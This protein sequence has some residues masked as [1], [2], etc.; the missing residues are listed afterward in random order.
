[1]FIVHSEQWTVNSSRCTVHNGVTLPLLCTQMQQCTLGLDTC[2]ETSFSINRTIFYG[3]HCKMKNIQMMIN[4][5]LTVASIIIGPLFLP[6]LFEYLYRRDF[7]PDVELDSYS[8][9]W[10]SKASPLSKNIMTHFPS[11]RYLLA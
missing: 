10:E 1:M 4:I 5:L 6:F 9:R 7:I 3:T 8:C 2:F 11:F